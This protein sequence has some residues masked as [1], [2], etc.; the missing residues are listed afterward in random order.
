MKLIKD[1]GLQFA[2]T[3]NKGQ[4]YSYG[5]YECEDCKSIVR[6]QHRQIKSNIC[7][8][9][10]NRKNAT[11]HGYNK[12][13]LNNIWNKIKN[14][15]YNKN[16]SDYR[17][18]GEKGIYMCKEWLDSYEAFRDWSLDNGY[19]KGLQ[20]DKDILCEKYNIYPKVYSPNTCMWVTKSENIGEK[21]SRNRGVRQ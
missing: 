4:R 15:C 18:Y 12:E 11:I 14:R 10:S 8:S 9:C 5:L 16:S 3:E 21:N 13:P 17:Y 19:R 6:K 20:L 2:T 7:R 1:L